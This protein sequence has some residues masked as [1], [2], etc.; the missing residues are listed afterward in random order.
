MKLRETIVI[1]A[2]ESQHLENCLSKW[3]SKRKFAQL[4]N[5]PSSYITLMFR[6]IK[7]YNPVTRGWEFEYRMVESEHKAL[8]KFIEKE[9]K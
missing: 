5:R 6:P 7:V 1:S 9:V 3:G 4:I 2:E 8:L